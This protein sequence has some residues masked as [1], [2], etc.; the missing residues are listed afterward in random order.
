M[1]AGNAQQ[2]EV[3]RV[4]GAA[5]AD[6]ED[7]VDLPAAPHGR[8]DAP[9]WSPWSAAMRLAR[10]FGAIALAAA[11][12][13]DLIAL[14]D[15]VTQVIPVAAET[16]F[17]DADFPAP[18]A[19]ALRDGRLAPS[20]E[21]APGLGINLAFREWIVAP[22]SPAVLWKADSRLHLFRH[23]FA[24]RDTVRPSF[25]PHG[26]PSCHPAI[27]RSGRVEAPRC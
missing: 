9:E 18:V 14:D 26:K 5:L 15:V 7:V 8:V 4:I 1:M 24:R 16:V 23:A 13:A 10:A 25:F 17:L 2:P 22:P 21:A 19:P 20:T 3:A 11:D 12:G 6:R 27:R